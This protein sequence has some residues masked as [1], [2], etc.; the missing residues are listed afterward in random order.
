MLA[1]YYLV[2][3]LL[4]ASNAQDCGCNMEYDPICASDNQIYRN[5]CHFLCAQAKDDSLYA[6]ANNGCKKTF[7]SYPGEVCI[8]SLGYSPVCG[9]DEQTYA[10]LCVLK[11][12]QRTNNSLKMVKVGPCE[13]G[14]AGPEHHCLCM[15][16]NM[17]VCG[18]DGI[19][20]QNKCSLQCTKMTNGDLEMHY[21]GPCRIVRFLG[22]NNKYNYRR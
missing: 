8:C 19:T 15:D 10:N 9:S 4:A 17:P 2:S 11:C 1:L 6:V 14:L 16:E 22:M 7:E 12:H 18:T 5:R 20:Y 3:T 13:N 21:R